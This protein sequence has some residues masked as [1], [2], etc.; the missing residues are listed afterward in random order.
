LI[1]RCS[2]GTGRFYVAHPNWIL[3]FLPG[4]LGATVEDCSFKNM[5]NRGPAPD[6]ELVQGIQNGNES[7]GE[8]LFEK[9]SNRVYYLALRELRS[10]ADADD[11]RAETFLRVL[12][13]IRNQQVRSPDSLSSYILGVA[14]NIIME[15]LRSPHRATDGRGLPELPSPEAEPELDDDVRQSIEGT[16]LRLKPREREFLR[17]Y[18]YDE[19]S[20]A[21]IARRLG[22][23]EERVRLVKHRCLKSFREIYERLTK[24]GDTKRGKRSL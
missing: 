17:L 2:P 12:K 18:Y 3:S 23:D 5:G 1:G 6:A 10:H 24:I 20:K 9:Y 13:A 21:E 11:V 22:V 15:S 14:R 16:I 4:T 19:L 7:A 8:D